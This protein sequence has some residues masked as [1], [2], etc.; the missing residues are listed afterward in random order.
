MKILILGADGMLGH[1]LLESYRGRHELVGTT[2]RSSY[3]S[4]N[5]LGAITKPRIYHDVDVTNISQVCCVLDDCRPDAVINAV[6]IVKQR[7][8]AHD[9]ILSLQI[10]SLFPHLLAREC[11]K[12]GA[13]MIHMSTDCVFS[14]RAGYYSDSA[15]SDADDLYGR[16]KYLGETKGNGVV[17]LRTSIIGLEIWRKQGLVE[18]FLSQSRSV[19]GFR[20][21]IY[22]GFTTEEMAHV[23]EI[24]LT[25]EI[26]PCGVYNVSSDPIDKYSLLRMLNSCCNLGIE[27]IPDDSVVCDRSLDSSIFRKD[28]CYTPPRWQSM[29]ESLSKQILVRRRM[30]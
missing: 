26:M 8:E 20:G 7:D 9:A 29:I 1:Q 16:T 27:I 17:T 25:S 13:R 4:A 5:P 3:V 2:R 10:N 14:G 23:I 6:G 15:I 19:Y 18:W 11:V 28:F 24:V 30:N 12:R 21:A 22:S